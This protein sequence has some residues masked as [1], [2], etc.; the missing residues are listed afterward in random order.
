MSHPTP[1]LR[2]AAVLVLGGL[3]LASAAWAADDGRR[4]VRVERYGIV[5]RVP[6]AWKL[7]EWA[8]N[9]RAFVLKLPQDDETPAGYVLCELGTAPVRLEEYQQRFQA[10]A[11]REARAVPRPAR[12]LV[13]NRIEPVD[14]ARYGAALHEL[15]DRRLVV[16][17]E[18]DGADGALWYEARYDVIREGLLYTFVLTSDE[19]HYDAYRLD[20]EEMFVSAQFSPPET[21]VEALPNGLWMQ[22]D[23][24]FALRLPKDWRPTFSPHDNVLLFATGQTHE[25]FSDSLIVMA[26][27]PQQLDLEKLRDTLPTEIKQADDRAQVEC[28]IVPQG[29]TVALETVVRTRRGPLD[30]TILERRFGSRAR[31]YEVK[32]TCESET[33][34]EIEA[35]LREC[36]DSFIEV[37]AAPGPAET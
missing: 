7:V 37:P 24:R 25:V 2:R 23:F 28:R 13:E 9:E 29:A 36:L 18:H 22:R 3:V 15:L 35:E 17:W 1:I 19:A 16:V 31:S 12:R 33:Y 6:Q 4:A 11:D 5:V 32:F 30:V 8:H 14:E 21:G 27:P 34:Q 20:F 26:K 10:T